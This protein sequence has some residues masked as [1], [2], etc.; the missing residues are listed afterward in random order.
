MFPCIFLIFPD[1]Q[2]AFQQNSN[3]STK[4]IFTLADDAFAWSPQALSG[5]LG[6]SGRPM[7]LAVLLGDGKSWQVLGHAVRVNK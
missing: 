2:M 4:T 5:L 7:M 6:V 3:L 1:S